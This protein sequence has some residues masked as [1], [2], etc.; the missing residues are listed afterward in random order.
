MAAHT[1]ARPATPPTLTPAIVAVDSFWPPEKETGACVAVAVED[2]AV[3]CVV[4]PTAALLAAAVAVALA[5]AIALAIDWPAALKQLELLLA[6]TVMKGATGVWLLSVDETWTVTTVPAGTS[7]IQ[8]KCPPGGGLVSA[9]VC[10][11][12]GRVDRRATGLTC[13]LCRVDE[14]DRVEDLVRGRV[15]KIAQQARVSPRRALRRFGPAKAM[16][17]P[18]L[19]LLEDERAVDPHGR[20]PQE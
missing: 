3:P 6:P 20:V 14:R 4:L 15:C 16:H 19:T 1:S 13:L 10:A 17:Q 8:A 18:R 7:A 2:D 11:L 9:G 12:A 5:L